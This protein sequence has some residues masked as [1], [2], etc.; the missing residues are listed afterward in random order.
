MGESR[1][2]A[3]CVI[4]LLDTGARTLRLRLDVSTRRRPSPVSAAV[5]GFGK[6]IVLGEIPLGFHAELVHFLMDC[7][8]FPVVFL[9]RSK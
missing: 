8:K 6:L 5:I 3:A 2:R 1:V 9:T 4:F 7:C